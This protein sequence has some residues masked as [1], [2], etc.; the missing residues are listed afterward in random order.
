MKKQK[1]V[2]YVMRAGTE[3]KVA[4]G[5]KDEGEEYDENYDENEN[6]HLVNE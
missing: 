4:L 3:I 1:G 2:L 6:G 5:C